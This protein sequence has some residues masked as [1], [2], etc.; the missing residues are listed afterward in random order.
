MPAAKELT[1]RQRT[2]LQWV[3]D[4]CP[5]DPEVPSTYK[6]TARTLEGHE[7][8]KV[9]GHGKT[10]Q[11]TVTERGKRVLAVE[12]EPL[13]ALDIRTELEDAGA[14]PV[15]IARTVDAALSA[16]AEIRFDLALLDG[17]LKGQ[18]V[19]G[20]SAHRRA[21]LGVGYVPQGR[22]VFPRMTV[23]ENL[24]IAAFAIWSVFFVVDR[25]QGVIDA[26]KSSI[27][28]ASKNAGQTI[29]LILLAY[30]LNFVGGLLCGIGTLITNWRDAAQHNIIDLS[31][32]Q[33]MALF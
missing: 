28:F 10:W 32:I 14:G 17:N 31:S 1:P 21:R 13:V 16:L 24:E 19:D 20:L 27:A 8:V 5:T 30:L 6:T 4:G 25:N 9:K 15:R 18:P 23:L 22:D 33:L 3:V 7:L 2:V 29:V 12:D 26:I 11:A